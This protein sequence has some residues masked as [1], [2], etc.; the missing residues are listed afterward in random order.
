MVQAMDMFALLP[1]ETMARKILS[2]FG[3]PVNPSFS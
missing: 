3:P 2:A 1:F